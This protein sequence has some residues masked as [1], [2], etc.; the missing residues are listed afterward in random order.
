M[1]VVTLSLGVV[2]IVVLILHTSPK[3][4]RMNPVAARELDR[5]G[6]FQRWLTQNGARGYIGEVGWPSGPDAASWNAVAS[7]WYN[8]AQRDQLWITAWT[9]G[10]WW[11]SGY[12]LAI[13]RFSGSASSIQAESQAPVV[14][15]H[16]TRGGSLTGID[17]AGGSFGTAQDGNPLYSNADPGTLGVDYH[18]DDY[19]TY[20]ALADRGVHLVRIAFT[21]ERLQPRLGE[22]LN[23]VAV[24]QLRATVAAAGRAGLGVILDMHNFG[25]YWQASRPGVRATREALGS[26][27]LPVTDFADAWARIAQAFAQEPSVL[28]YG[29]MNEPSGLAPTVRAGAKQWEV[30]SQAAVEGIRATGDRRTVFVSGY[31]S[32]SP[33]L[34]PTLHPVPW[35][36]DPARAVRYEAHQYFDEDGS[37]RYALSY[38]AETTAAA[39]GPQLQEACS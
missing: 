33:E 38:A 6:V 14:E 39:Q 11:P 23:P 25:A 16:S 31:L 22:A 3:S 30:A 1:L 36:S 28:G 27:A 34:I 17:V 7:T 13:Y 2:T 20:R 37:G 15:D 4:C 9:A 18:Y 8:A 35:I 24:E 26:A 32:S 21:W 29:L 19:A 10:S 5:L 12:P